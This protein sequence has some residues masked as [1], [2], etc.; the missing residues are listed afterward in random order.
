M[1]NEGC[2]QYWKQ[3]TNRLDFLVILI[4]VITLVLHAMTPLS[5][6]L[7]RMMAAIGL[8]CVWLQMFLWFRLFD[9]LAQYVDLIAETI[10]DIQNF[11]FVFLELM[12]MFM[13]VFYMLQI[14]RVEQGSILYDYNDEEASPSFMWYAFSNQVFLMMG[15]FG[16]THLNRSNKDFRDQEREFIYLEN[17]LVFVIFL[18]SVFIGQIVVFNMLIA[19]MAET[20][21]RHSD[22]LDENGKR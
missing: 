19:I 8:L 11:I 16:G 17:V 18:A 4:N 13:V 22:S 20:F 14:S 7:L 3:T 9:S 10:Y 1:K 6:I 15:D 21:G 5:L 2:S 12:V